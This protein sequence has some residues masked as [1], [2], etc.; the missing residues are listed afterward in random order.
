MWSCVVP[1]QVIKFV[2]SALLASFLVVALT[3]V[4]WQYENFMVPLQHTYP[5]LF[6]EKV[7][8]LF[9]YGNLLVDHLPLKDQEAQCTTYKH[10]FY[11]CY[12]VLK[13]YFL[14]LL[15]WNFI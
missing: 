3:W 9:T 8:L 11:E 12:Q 6:P 14:P 15:V 2:R 7:L 5:L 10:N 4:V 13:S 1:Q